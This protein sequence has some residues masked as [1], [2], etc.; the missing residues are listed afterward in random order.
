MA[1]CIYT[2]K[3]ISINKF[4]SYKNQSVKPIDGFK[5]NNIM[6]PPHLASKKRATEAE[7]KLVI[8]IRQLFNSLSSDNIYTIKEQLRFIIIAKAKTSEMLSEVAEEILLNF[9]INENNIKNYMHL[10]NAISPMCNAIDDTNS[11]SR[12]IG[13]FFLNNCR[14]MIFENISEEKV[15]S[16]AVMD[17]YD[18]DE[19]DK[20]MIER[21]RMSN[22]IITLCYLY[23]QR[24]TGTIKIRAIQ[25]YSVLNT[26]FKN[27]DK[28]QKS[29]L[30]LINSDGECND[31]DEYEILKKMCTIY[32]EQLYTFI[33]KSGKDYFEDK[34]IINGET[35]GDLVR[36]FKSDIVP[37]L[38][39]AFLISKCD[40]MEL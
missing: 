22:L 26:I 29:M 31:E 12:T 28:I 21:E 34:T 10:L 1:T 19:L 3:T 11:V 20:Y 7:D 24:D 6:I 25:L 14:N 2:P 27:Y 40:E 17:Q 35:M 32:A 16:L 30:Q 4:L 5:L 37:T 33:S 8:N 38:T 15:R 36:R 39:E 18:P 13:N 23:E 9:L